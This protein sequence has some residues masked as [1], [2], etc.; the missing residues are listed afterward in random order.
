MTYASSVPAVIDA[1][2][3]RFTGW[4]TLGLSGVAVRDGP[5]LVQESG[6]EA[7]AVGYTGNQGEDVVTGTAA[8]EGLGGVPDRERY[9]VLCAVEVIDP[10]GDLP[11]TRARAYDL[12][13]MCGQAIEADHT[14]SRVVLRASTG[15]GALQQQQQEAGVLARVVFPVNVDAYTSR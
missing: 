7:V 4:P 3:M 10:G 2:V 5:Q 1:L 14:L 13:A 9:A 11:A 6:L 15:M 12:L 8:P